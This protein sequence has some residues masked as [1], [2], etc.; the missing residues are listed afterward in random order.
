MPCTNTPTQ[1][2]THPRTSD[3][4]LSLEIASVEAVAAADGSTPATG[5][6]KVQDMEF[7]LDLRSKLLMTEIP[8]ELEAELQVHACR[9]QRDAHTRA[10]THTR[11]RA[12]ARAHTHTNAPP[13]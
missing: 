13:V 7:L 4:V 1:T 9:L 2:H 6:T 12:R 11:A 10:C 3:Q 8:E 5:A